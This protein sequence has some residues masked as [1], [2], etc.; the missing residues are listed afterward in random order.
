MMDVRGS[1]DERGSMERGMSFKRSG[2]LKTSQKL[3]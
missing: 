3:S 1:R 2:H